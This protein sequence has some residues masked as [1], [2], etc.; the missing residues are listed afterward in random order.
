MRKPKNK[1]L[2]NVISIKAAVKVKSNAHINWMSHGHLMPI[3]VQ[4]FQLIMNDNRYCSSLS[5]EVI[6]D[7]LRKDNDLILT[8]L[9][10]FESITDQVSGI[11]SS[12]I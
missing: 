11:N 5:I 2:R 9:W 8:S 12:S 4:E 3:C 6:V 1:V 10:E 7:A